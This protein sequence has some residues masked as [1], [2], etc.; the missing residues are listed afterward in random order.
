MS[1]TVR[2]QIALRNRSALATAVSALGGQVLGD[3][4]HRLY[5]SREVGFA[6]KLPGWRY[7]I[8][9]REDSTLAYDDYHGAWGNPRDLE[10]LKGRYAIEAARAEADRLGWY[11]EEQGEFLIIYHPDGG[12]LTV[13]MGGEVDASGFLGAAC[14]AASSP[15]EAA[16]GRRLEATTKPERW[17]ERARVQEIN[18]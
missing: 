4:E 15:L 18:P 16:M 5:S 1:H 11:C 12:T 7:P 3:G 9:V 17:Q 10:R 13:G 8:V 2:V 6:V 14:D